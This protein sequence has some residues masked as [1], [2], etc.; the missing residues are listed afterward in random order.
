MTIFQGR[1]LITDQAVSLNA[2]YAATLQ[3]FFF[4]LGS[5]NNQI[6]QLI[7]KFYST[8]SPFCRGNYLSHDRTPFV[9]EEPSFSQHKVLIALTQENIVSHYSATTSSFSHY[10]KDINYQMKLLNQ[11]SVFLKLTTLCP[12]LLYCWLCIS[13]VVHAKLYMVPLSY[14]LILILYDLI[15]HSFIHSF[16]QSHLSFIFLRL[17][18][19]Y[20]S[21]MVK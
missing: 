15:V 3:Y 2:D 6:G 11:C 16:S 17:S 19:Y 1:L 20:V 21:G 12:A 5:R 4:Y 10:S 7:I 14:S 8:H 9:N 18:K 13:P